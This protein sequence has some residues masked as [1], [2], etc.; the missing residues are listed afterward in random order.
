M[1]RRSEVRNGHHIA[2]HCLEQAF[3]RTRIE[4]PQHFMGPDPRDQEAAPAIQHE[5]NRSGDRRGMTMPKATLDA[6]LNTDPPLGGSVSEASAQVGTGHARCLRA[7]LIDAERAALRIVLRTVRL[8]LDRI[9][10]RSNALGTDGVEARHVGTA[11]DQWRGNIRHV[12]RIEPLECLRGFQHTAHRSCPSRLD[13][14][15]PI[16]G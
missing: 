7:C 5:G 9:G 14:V 12:D 16:G 15:L 10:A 6:P 1:L 4:V 8:C 11:I 3:N 13:Y 2:G